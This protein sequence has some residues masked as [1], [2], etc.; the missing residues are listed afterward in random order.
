MVRRYRRLACIPALVVSA[1]IPFLSSVAFAAPPNDKCAG[2]EVIPPAGPFPHLSTFIPDLTT[3]TTNGDPFPSCVN[4]FSRGVW[5]AFTPAVTAEYQIGTCNPPTGTTIDDTVLSIYT[6]S[7][8]ACS[9][10]MLEIPGGCN[11]DEC[12][13]RSALHATLTAGT[14]YYIVAAKWGTGAPPAGESAMQI[15]VTKSPSNDTCETAGAIPL[16]RTVHGSLTLASNDYEVSTSAPACY[17]LPFPPAPIGQSATPSS[18]TGRDVAYTFTAPADGSYT[19]KAQS[20]LGGGNLILHT[21][22]S[23]PSGAGPHTLTDCLGASNRNPNLSDYLAAEEVSCVPLLAGQTI[24]VFVDE[25]TPSSLGVRFNLEAIPCTQEAEPNDVPLLAAPLSCGLQGTIFP[26]FDEDYFSLGTVP[27]GSR[28]FALVDSVAANTTD[29]D[30]RVTTLKDTL[31]YDDSNNSSPWGGASGNIAGCP[32]PSGESYLKVNQFSGMEEVEP[33]HLYALVQP[34]G[35]GLGG[36][37]AM[38]EV[39]PNDTMST[40]NMAGNMFFSGQITTGGATGDRDLFKFCADEGDLIY[41]SIDGDPL[42]DNTPIDPTLILLDS[43][44]KQLLNWSDP[45]NYSWNMPNPDTLSGT[46]PYSPGE[47]AVY[48]AT[49]SGLHYAGLYTE[50]PGT[51]YGEGDYLYS[52][53]IDCMRGDQLQTDLALSVTDTP[54]PIGSDEN[55]DLKID[56]VNQGP[57]TAT[58]AM[59]MMTVPANTTFVS[60][61]GPAE[62]SCSVAGNDIM[63]LTT[64]FPAGGAASFAVQLHTAICPLPGTIKHSVMI[65]SDTLD[66][67]PLNNI[68]EESTEIVDGTACEDGD[69]CTANDVCVMGVCQGGPP[70]DCNDNNECTKDVCVAGGGCIHTNVAGACDDGNVCTTGDIC[71]NGQCKGN[72]TTVCDDGDACTDDSCDAILG[73]V[74]KFNTAPC[75]DGNPCSEN[76]RCASGTC[77]AGSPVVCVPLN[78]CQTGGIC[79]ASM[80]GCAYFLKPDGESCDDGN[81][82]T[83]NDSCKGGACIDSKPKVCPSPPNECLGAGTCNPDT[84]ACKYPVLGSDLDGDGQGDACDDDIDGDGLTNEQETGWGMNPA[85]KDSDGDTIDDCTEA[86]PEDDGSCFNGVVCKVD[87]PA[88][89]DNDDRIDA[90]DSDSDE[91]GVSDAVEAGD[92]L[93]STPPE[94]SNSDGIADYRDPKI[95]NNGQPDMELGGGCACETAVGAKNEAI[96]GF[97]LVGWGMIASW[98]L[99]KR[100]P[101]RASRINAR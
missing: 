71:S 51:S 29:L 77:M 68:V 22:A 31:E 38:A 28:V 76:D 88:N 94:D 86:C 79:D 43:T 59:L 100:R 55:L 8:G 45:A 10:S 36:S 17:A 72:V 78:D 97:W 96:S 27:A 18:A 44:G 12:S 54:D 14:T 81:A 62:W 95:A 67:E 42:R 83:T 4:T 2:A 46:Y 47:A 65:M 58:N 21:A 11:D 23:C 35:S 89:T 19:F 84:G 66:S 64:C 92:T 69:V 60:V 53:G 52:I 99:R 30:L 70:N 87:K 20:T 74:T 16:N 49:Y 73:C 39:E 13:H 9:G 101:A 6:S 82:C 1:M 80:G 5:Y 57:R 91:D 48:R 33:Y 93:L 40:A 98:W 25:A 75:E 61:M 90:L 50:F 26:G 15:E 34:P 3:A 37:S 7:N 56:V 24:Y 32:L 63:C 41:L 85:S